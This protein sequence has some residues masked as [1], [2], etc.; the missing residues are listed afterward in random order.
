MITKYNLFTE[1]KGLFKT[2]NIILY[3]KILDFKEQ[4]RT[5]QK[6]Y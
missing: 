4:N 1:N 3:Q 5:E 2:P 6:V